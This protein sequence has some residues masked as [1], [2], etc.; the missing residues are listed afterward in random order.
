MNEDYIVSMDHIHKS[1]PGVKALDDVSFHLRAGEVMALLGEN[2]AGKSTLVKIL[3]GV[4]HKDK[5]RLYVNGKEYDDLN[6]KLARE[7]GVAIIHQ[8]LNMCRHLTVAENMFLGREIKG[9][10]ALKNSEMEKEAKK[11]L[12]ELG[13]D[14]SPRQTVGELPVS[15]QQMIE[16][17]K[18][19][20]VN[21]KILIMDEPTS[22]LTSRE[23]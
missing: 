3:S 17:A 18:A 19:L 23:P 12:D 4:Y 14:I 8:E 6:P 13:V 11:Y 21:A 16:I 22:A 7:A 20:S 5:G 15:K 10:V 2:G 9:K 1:F